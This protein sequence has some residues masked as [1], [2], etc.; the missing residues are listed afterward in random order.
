MCVY[1]YVHMHVCAQKM[2]AMGVRPYN[3]MECAKDQS[4]KVWC[5]WLA[6]YMGELSSGVPEL[7]WDCRPVPSCLVSNST[8]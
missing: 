5:A 3:C 6:G 1:M 4:W 7:D 8:S 2:H